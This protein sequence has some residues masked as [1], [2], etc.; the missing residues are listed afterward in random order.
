VTHA[1]WERL[2][3]EAEPLLPEEERSYRGHQL[4]FTDIEKARIWATVTKLR[5][6]LTQ[7]REQ[8]AAEKERAEEAEGKLAREEELRSEELQAACERIQMHQKQIAALNAAER[9]LA[10]LREAHQRAERAERD[11][12]AQT[13]RTEEAER[14][15]AKLREELA[16]MTE[17]YEGEKCQV[18]H[19]ARMV[20]A[21]RRSST[22]LREACESSGHSSSRDTHN[23]ECPICAALASVPSAPKQEPKAPWGSDAE[24]A[25]GTLS[26]DWRTLLEKL[27]R[28]C[29]YIRPRLSPGVHD[30][31]DAA[32][33][34]LAANVAP[35]GPDPLAEVRKVVA[36][37]RRWQSGE[38][39]L[40]ID[41]LTGDWA[42]RLEKAM[43]GGQ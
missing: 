6:E 24:A 34:A 17:H 21:E 10:A 29:E 18:S 13:K 37:M 15:L 30:A 3:E 41:A 33:S 43:G 38:H 32:Q 42:D 2:I 5:T 12:A 8:L 7:V 19:L 4:H 9:D 14:D 23:F 22:S 25:Q 11:L 28:A 16:A 39:M 31:L 35:P 1:E 27:A 40:P 36:E 26:P 20:D